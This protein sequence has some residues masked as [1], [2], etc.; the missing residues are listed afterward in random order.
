MWL[1]WQ[2][3]KTANSSFW[4]N[5]RA[6]V[7]LGN[8]DFYPRNIKVNLKNTKGGDLRV[9][10]IREW[11]GKEWRKIESEGEWVEV[12]LEGLSGLLLEIF[13]EEV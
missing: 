10:R 9:V 2:D 4:K 7:V 5:G 3:G 11:N 13:Y 8:L 12:H 6:I 1:D